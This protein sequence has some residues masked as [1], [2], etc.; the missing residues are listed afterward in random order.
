MNTIIALES[1]ET[2]HSGPSAGESIM[3]ETAISLAAGLG[4]RMRPIT[5]TLP[6]PLV[7]VAGRTLID[8]AIS[9]FD[10]EERRDASGHVAR[11]RDGIPGLG[12]CR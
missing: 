2:N 12:R 4:T 11:R 10:A 8:H 9:R 7:A 1:A 3:P 5:D 6:K